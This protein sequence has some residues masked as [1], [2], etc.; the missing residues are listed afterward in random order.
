MCGILA[1]GPGHFGEPYWVRPF[2]GGHPGVS[3]EIADSSEA[4]EVPL[5][6]V[7]VPAELAL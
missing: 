7:F 2:D 3:L 6:V 1:E 5:E 4:G